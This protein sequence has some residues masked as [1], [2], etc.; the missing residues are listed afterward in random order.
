MIYS[1]QISD[2]NAN[3]EMLAGDIK[4][5]LCWR[6][7]YMEYMELNICIFLSDRSLRPLFPAGY[8]YETQLVC[9]QLAIDGHHD[10]D[11][12]S[13]NAGELDFAE[14]RMFLYHCLAFAPKIA[15]G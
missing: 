14:Q 6:V 3:L 9:N 2:L 8:F 11:V 7:S 10:P 15:H 12:V 5:R 13:I 4:M 1:G